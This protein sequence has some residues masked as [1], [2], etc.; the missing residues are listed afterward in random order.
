MPME[1]NEIIKFNELKI[2]FQKLIDL[3]LL[4]CQNFV[5]IKTYAD[6]LNQIIVR[7]PRN[8]RVS[9]NEMH[10]FLNLILMHK[11][12]VHIIG[13]PEAMKSCILLK[14]LLTVDHLAESNYLLYE[15]IDDKSF[16][17]IKTILS[18]NEIILSSSS[19]D[20]NEIDINNYIKYLTPIE[21]EMI[22]KRLQ[23]CT[24]FESALYHLIERPIFYPYCTIM[25]YSI[26]CE[27]NM[28]T[29]FSVDNHMKLLHNCNNEPD[30]VKKVIC[31][32]ILT[33][34]DKSR[35]EM[36]A[37]YL[38]NFCK[39]IQKYSHPNCSDDLRI[40]AANFICHIVN[41]Y[42]P[43]CI[44]T[45]ENLLLLFNILLS[46][47]CDDECDIREI[48]GKIMIK[49]LPFN[50]MT[51]DNITLYDYSSF[52]SVISTV[53]EKLLCAFICTTFEGLQNQFK[54][55]TWKLLLQLLQQQ[56]NE[57]HNNNDDNMDENCLD[58]DIEIF[59]KNELNVFGEPLMICKIIYRYLQ[60]YVMDDDTLMILEKREILDNINFK[61]F[62]KN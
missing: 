33:Y 3:N 34:L 31:K 35:T 9:T 14:L 44:A 21:I 36:N 20:I 30:D 19:S 1:K 27:M 2:V 8:E 57:F 48:I 62:Q 49:L 6:T 25:C 46:L 38:F 59:D 52:K 55:N 23:K 15:S 22:K 43:Y 40:V 39:F 45:K 26:L 42:W 41:S 37:E 56:L 24:K 16:E 13:L 5:L 50:C 61:C 18:I 47:V 7:L 60:M 53:A 58:N 51:S 17:Y 54:S 10:H 11:E 28:D 12:S 32:Y 29:N 4:K